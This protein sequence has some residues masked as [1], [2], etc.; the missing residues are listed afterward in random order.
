[1]DTLLY[2]RDALR[3]PRI[4]L[5]YSANIRLLIYW[6]LYDTL[7][8]ASDR[9]PTNRVSVIRDMHDYSNSITTRLVARLG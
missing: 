6:L 5:M 2:N 8:T 9:A 4:R 3:S 7:A 1:M